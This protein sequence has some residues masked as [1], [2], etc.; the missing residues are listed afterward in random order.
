MIV[1][2][3]DGGVEELGLGRYWYRGMWLGE[4]TPVYKEGKDAL[5]KV[6]GIPAEFKHQGRIQSIRTRGLS[7]RAGTVGAR[8]VFVSPSG[9]IYRHFIRKDVENG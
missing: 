9:R 5:D 2:F 7:H 3:L 4:T 6:R 1:G 8:D